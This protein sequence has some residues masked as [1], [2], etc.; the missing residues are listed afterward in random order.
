[1]VNAFA[2]AVAVRFVKGTKATLGFTHF[3][4]TCVFEMDGLDS[5]GNH[6]VFNN[7]IVRM[8]TNNIPYSIHW[9][10][11]NEPLNKDR[12]A[13]IYGDK[14]RT[15]KQSRAQLLSEETRNVFVNPFMQK[16]GLD[17]ALKPF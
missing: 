16:C 7:V 15:W 4:H 10:K 11:L 6:N 3:E 9:G 13:A 12:I 14:L 8:E 1:A 17:T 2:G 5:K